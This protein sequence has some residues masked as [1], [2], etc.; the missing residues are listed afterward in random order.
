[1]YHFFIKNVIDMFLYTSVFQKT[2]E[3]TGICFYEHKL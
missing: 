3:I 1:M 2:A